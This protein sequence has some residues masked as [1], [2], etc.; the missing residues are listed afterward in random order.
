MDRLQGVLYLQYC[1]LLMF[2]LRLAAAGGDSAMPATGFSLRLIHRDSAESPLRPRGNLTA[3][4]L[5]RRLSRYTAARL[6]FLESTLHAAPLD[7]DARPM[8]LQDCWQFYAQLA[9]GTAPVRI[10][11]LI[12]TGS[13][14]IW[15]Q[16][17]PCNPCFNQR[18]PIYDPSRSTTAVDAACTDPLCTP[19]MFHCVSNKCVYDI[20]YADETHSAGC[21][22]RE[23]FM[24]PSRQGRR[25]TTIR[26]LAFGKSNETYPHDFFPGAGYIGGILG[27]GRGRQS[28]AVQLA[29]MLGN[30]FSYCFPPVTDLSPSYLRFGDDIP[31]TAGLKTVRFVPS[32]TDVSHYNVALTDLSFNG[33]RMRF[34]SRD[35]G[36]C[37]MDSG[38]TYTILPRRVYN[39]V[40]RVMI[41]Y[42]SG[43]P[44]LRRVENSTSCHGL[45]LCYA[46]EG[47]FGAYPSM[48]FHFAA[49]RGAGDVELGLPKERLFVP[50]PGKFC[51]ALGAWDEDMSVIGAVQQANLRL[52]YDLGAQQLQFAD[53]NCRQA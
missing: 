33:R 19:G 40:E 21:L 15:T 11:L 23:T 53:A 24:L 18:E 12:D 42:F 3:E 50:L 20:Q 2:L 28:F 30:R 49:V 44:H 31:P 43:F 9:I 22:A 27:M 39:R 14:L 45:D 4:Q 17:K 52:I 36:A 13:D 7:N 32:R 5:V 16:S 48:S 47:T 38:S 41:D 1:I 6:L 8:V 25:L 51:L 26:S 10:N 29:G 37:A 35:F 34:T 46:Y